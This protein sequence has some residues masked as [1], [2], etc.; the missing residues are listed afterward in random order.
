VKYV[1][2]DL[3]PNSVRTIEIRE[4]K[5]YCV[6]TFANYGDAWAFGAD[7]AYTTGNF[8]SSHGC[9]SRVWSFPTEE[10]CHSVAFAMALKHF[11]PE[12]L[13]DSC[14]NDEQRHMAVLITARLNTFMSGQSADAPGQLGLFAT[15]LLSGGN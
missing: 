6:L 3:E 4:K 7:L 15:P 9:F 13:T 11:R 8:H 12:V 14:A 5:A 10:E 1:P 2:D